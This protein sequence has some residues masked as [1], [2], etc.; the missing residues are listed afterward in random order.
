G[1]VRLAFDGIVV[2][3]WAE[4]E[5]LPVAGDGEERPKAGVVR[6]FDVCEPGVP[7]RVPGRLDRLAGLQH[8]LAL[9]LVR[10]RAGDADRKEDDRRMDDIAAVA[11]PVAGDQPEDPSR[12]RAAAHELE[13]DR[14][15]DEGRERVRK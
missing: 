12:R 2:F 14:S 4:V 7:E 8:P 5:A 13:H 15:P 6:A 3:A 11:A 9:G 1:L 10:A